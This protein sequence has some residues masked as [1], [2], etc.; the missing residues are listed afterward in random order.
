MEYYCYI[1]KNT[2][3]PHIKR[4]YNGI[5][6]NM[7]RRLRQHNQEIKGG[8]KYTKSFGN[9]TWEIIAMIGKL[10]KITA[11][12]LEWRIKK[13]TG[14]KRRPS[15]YN[16][17]EGRIKSLLEIMKMDNFTKSCIERKKLEFDIYIDKNYQNI[18]NDLILDDNKKIMFVDN[19]DDF[20]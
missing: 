11:L 15:K 9:K 19:F 6:N 18:L 12:Q 2:H 8:A 20:L 5:T 10:D 7:K 17:A 13:P 14:Q 16:S 1:L 4:T 3:E